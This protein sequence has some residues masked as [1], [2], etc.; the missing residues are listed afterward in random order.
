MRVERWHA[1]PYDSIIREQLSAFLSFN[2]VFCGLWS[3]KQHSN[4]HHGYLDARLTLW[5]FWIIEVTPPIMSHESGAVV[6]PLLLK[7]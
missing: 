7:E 4:G 1:R 5:M 2:A 3:A 6:T